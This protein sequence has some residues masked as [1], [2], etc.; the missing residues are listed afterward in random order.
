MP[1]RQH[2]AVLVGRPVWSQR[3]H[4]TI[5]EHLRWRTSCVTVTE[6]FVARRDARDFRFTQPVA[7][8]GITEPRLG[9]CA[10]R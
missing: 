6:I 7:T 1:T 5:T 4:V 2:V 9:A 8:T 10:S 3:Q